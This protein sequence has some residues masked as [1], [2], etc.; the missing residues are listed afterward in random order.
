MVSVACVVCVVWKRT[1]AQPAFSWDWASLPWGV[2]RVSVGPA[3]ADGQ[4]GLARALSCPGAERSAMAVPPALSKHR[5]ATEPAAGGQ[6]KHGCCHSAL[7]PMGNASFLPSSPGAL[8]R[9]RT[10]TP[11][12][13]AGLSK[14]LFPG[15]TFTLDPGCLVNRGRTFFSP[16]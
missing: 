5:R 15:Q 9:E 13:V 12:P 1:R 8:R 14:P 6:S 7:F 4:G 2:R 3:R 16:P 11:R 10:Q